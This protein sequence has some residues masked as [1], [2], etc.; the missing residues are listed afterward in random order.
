MRLSIF[1]NLTI[2]LTIFYSC[3]NKVTEHRQSS[4]SVSAFEPQKILKTNMG[5]EVPVYS[6]DAF[7]KNVLQRKESSVTYVINFWATWCGPCVAE[8]PYFFKLEE[9][10]S[11]KDVKFVYVSLDF[12]KNLETK[13]LPFL[14]NRNIKN[15]VVVLDQK[16]VNTW[17]SKIDKKWSGAIPA[18]L[19]FNT[20]KRVFLEQ[21]FESSEELEKALNEIIH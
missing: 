7:E 4:K 17:M 21:N 8:L 1:L 15:K 12:L 6:F 11:G 18:T 13:L 5:T 3:N 2:L 20:K 14:E 19:I 9:Q 16:D 10:Y